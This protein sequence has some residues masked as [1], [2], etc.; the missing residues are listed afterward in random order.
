MIF[1]VVLLSCLVPNVS[2]WNSTRS[3][4]VNESFVN[5][6]ILQPTAVTALNFTNW[7]SSYPTSFLPTSQI[8]L[9]ND[10][11]SN[12]TNNGSRD[13][14]GYFPYTTKIVLQPITPEPTT[15]IVV[16]SSASRPCFIFFC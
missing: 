7:T 10:T 1:W 2:D 4:S 12:Q 3:P 9:I 13:D 16:S 8:T 6:T 11:E 15:E 5:T 14:F